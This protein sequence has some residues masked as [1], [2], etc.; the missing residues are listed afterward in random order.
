MLKIYKFPVRHNFKSVLFLDVDGVLN[1]ELFFKA[2]YEKLQKNNKIPMFRV[3]KKYLRKLVK[4]K[5]IGTLDYYK[6]QFD[7]ERIAWLNSLCEATD[8]AVVLSASMRSRWTP[9]Q[10]NRIFRHAGATFTIID[11]TGRSESRIRGVEIHEWLKENCPYWFGVNYYDFYRYAIID[12]DSDMLLNQQ[13]HF[14]HTDNYSGLT[15]NTCYKIKR[16]LTHV[17]F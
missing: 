14:F 16:F 9:L 7:P 5:E 12:D 4:S 15:P 8:A 6:S 2:R 11:K 13:H 1:H 3:V 17:T 10:L